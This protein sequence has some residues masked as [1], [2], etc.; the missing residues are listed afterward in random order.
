MPLHLRADFRIM[1]R[2]SDK[3][4]NCTRWHGD[5]E[6]KTCRDEENGNTNDEHHCCAKEAGIQE[7]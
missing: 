5:D 4:P 7:A 6:T 2:C 1:V 3:S